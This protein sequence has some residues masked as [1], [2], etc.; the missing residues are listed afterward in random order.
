MTATHARRIKVGFHRI[1]LTLAVVCG[2][3][4][5]LLIGL[6]LVAFNTPDGF[7]QVFLGGLGLLLAG[8][9]YAAARAI[10]WIIAGFAGDS[11]QIAS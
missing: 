3:P 8:A 1:G 5:T 6:G 7:H 11:D 2:V 10:G 9:G 4:G